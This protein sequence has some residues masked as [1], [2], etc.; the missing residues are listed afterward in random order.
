VEWIKQH[1]VF[2]AKDANTLIST[3]AI[4]PQKNTTNVA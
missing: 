1:R 4:V 2:T 3:I